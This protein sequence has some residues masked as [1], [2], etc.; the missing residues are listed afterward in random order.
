MNCECL[1]PPAEVEG[2]DECISAIWS[3]G[4]FFSWL[5]DN[6]KSI[7]ETRDSD[8]PLVAPYPYRRIYRTDLGGDPT[9]GVRRR[10]M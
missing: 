6:G 2:P 4:N 1:C 5:L 7:R 8:V 9:E 10:R 3:Y